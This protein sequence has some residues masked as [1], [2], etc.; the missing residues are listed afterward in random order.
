MKKIAFVGSSGGNLFKQ[1]GNDIQGMMKEIL[2]QTR[3]A[4]M[5]VAAVQYILASSS[6]D[7]AGPDSP[8]KLYTWKDNQLY[9][10][11]EGTLSEVNETAKETD[12]LIADLIKEGKIDGVMFV[13][14]N[15]ENVNHLTFTAAIRDR[16]SPCR[17][18]WKLCSK[19]TEYGWES[20]L[21]FRDNRNHQ[22]HQSGGLYHCFCKR[23]GNPLPPG[24]R[25]YR[26]PGSRKASVK[27]LEANQFSWDHDDQPPGVYCHGPLPC[28]QQNPGAFHS[29]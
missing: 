18:G 11:K 9:L 8:T 21:G 15:P 10:E 22:P 24:H 28:P 27:Y 2:L 1:G 14:A 7:T 19:G 20:P 6:L 25:E 29:F 3:A 5:E 23:M 12:G 4:E 26:N 13:S 17:N 16:P